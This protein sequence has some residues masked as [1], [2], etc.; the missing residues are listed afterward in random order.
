MNRDSA[1]IRPASLIRDD[2]DR[3]PQF[4]ANARNIREDSIDC[5]V[6]ACG[7][8][9]GP[10]CQR[11]GT[12]TSFLIILSLAG[13]VQG[14]IESYFRISA[15]QAANEHGFDPI[16]VDWLLVTSGIAQGVFAILVVYWG[17]RLH[18]I[19]WLGE[20]FMLQAVGLL[21]LVIPTLTHNSA[22]SQTIDAV[23]L[24]NVCILEQSA[25]LQTERPHGITTLV[26][27]FIVQALVGITN[28]AFY[29]LGLSYLDDNLKEHQSPGYVGCAI[30]AR[31]WGHQFGV[32][33]SLAVGAST[34]GW[35]LGWVI[36]GP[37]IFVLG[38]LVSLF[39]KRLLSTLV[40]QAA[41]DI[42]ETATNNNSQSFP[43]HKWLADVS[44][45]AS[46]R[47]LFSNSILIFNLLALVFIQTGVINFNAHEQ[48]YLQSRFLLPTSDANGLNDEWTSRLITNLLRPPLVALAVVVA[49]L[50]IAKANPSPRKL[51]AWNIFVGLVAVGTFIGFIFVT[52]ENERIAGAYR[53]KLTKPFCASNC[54]C[55][56]N[57]LFSPVCP[58]D[59]VFTYF[60][61][62]HAGCQTRTELN[63]VVVYTNCSCGVDTE[64][65]LRE[66]GIAT[67]GACGMADCQKYWIIFQV[68][69]VVVA[70]LLA[71]G[72]IGKFIISI[73][74]VLPQ[75]KALALS[76]ELT[77]VGLVVYLP[78][79]VAY[80]AIAA[81]ACQL[82][83]SDQQRCFIHEMPFYGTSLNVLTAALIT[84]GIIFDILV[85]YLVR[86]LPLY[87][88]DPEDAYR[89][90]EMRLIT[91]QI[92]NDA[93]QTTSP[94]MESQPL[95]TLQPQEL[96]ATSTANSFVQAS[97][98][99]ANDSP[100]IQSI[101]NTQARYPR[102]VRS[103]SPAAG[104]AD[105]Y[106]QVI[107][108]LPTRPAYSDSDDLS[109][110]RS[111][112]RNDDDEDGE[113]KQL[114]HSNG[115][116]THN[117]R[118]YSSV[119]PSASGI[120]AGVSTPESPYSSSVSS[121]DG[122]V[123]NTRTKGREARPL[124]PETDF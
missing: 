10:G 119:N 81:S 2:E 33:I 50:I 86:D 94:E 9:N 42:I 35:W 23:P 111:L 117:L 124:S 29:C 67:E 120:A 55:P 44:L 101:Q 114:G 43:T 90:V 6:T 69:T 78:G 17:N 25:E 121:P 116:L 95:A 31:I 4:E 15:Q 46:L 105:A 36:I 41:D 68:L 19:S 24:E 79:M 48:N 91:Q 12:S 51:A 96:D 32:A 76:V 20:I 7:C 84:I 83:S 82:W 39:P 99:A 8:C 98:I 37:I 122:T 3:L 108:Q 52:C 102:I 13:F 5:G 75:D 60:S 63:D 38:F 92:R 64:L 16:I 100:V 28:T 93:R 109:E 71:S 61:P 53:G 73:R 77:L 104:T 72:L 21:L 27:M 14:G 85:F 11:L 66:S 47:R 40:R 74:A 58:Q 56:E 112:S 22:E 113:S 18:R 57:V 87:G 80:Q 103:I 89:P 118:D 70:A 1:M 107:R 115:P 49:G 54:I 59:S 106:S 88:D 97:T 110:F 34:L 45:S 26:L 30:A 62:C 65:I 123:G